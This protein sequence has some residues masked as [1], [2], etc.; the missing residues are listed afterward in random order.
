MSKLKGTSSTS[1]LLREVAYEKIK[2]SI[3]DEQ[4]EPGSF[5]SERE[6]IELLQMSKTPIKSALTRLETEGFVTVSSKQGII[7][8]DLS[9]DRIMDIYDLRTALETFNCQQLTGKLTEEQCE[10]LEENL[11]ETEEIVTRLD[12][13]AFTNADHTF[14]LLICQH[15]GNQEIYRVLLNYQDHLQRITFRHLRKDPNRMKQFWQEH[16]L[17]YESLKHGNL[18]CVEMMRNHLQDSKRKLF[19]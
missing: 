5:L 19:W 17:M 11:S 10:E 7:I 3:L 4:F 9:I 2:E 1:P 12:V 15:V 16:C 8:N 18:Q 6:L 14:H 13:K